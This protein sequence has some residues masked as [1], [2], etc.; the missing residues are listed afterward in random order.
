MSAY[1]RRGGSTVADM[2]S[3]NAL[4]KAEDACLTGSPCTAPVC[5]PPVCLLSSCLT[6]VAGTVLIL[7]GVF[8]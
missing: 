7:R 6:H 5:L 2:G 3:D 8:T 4:Q 1:T